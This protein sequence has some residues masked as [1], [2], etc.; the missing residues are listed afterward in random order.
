VAHDIILGLKEAAAFAR[1]EIWL[2]VR[3]VDVPESVDV[4]ASAYLARR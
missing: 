1:G 2:P 3:M 4:R